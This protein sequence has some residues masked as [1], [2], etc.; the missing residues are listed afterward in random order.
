MS[1]KKMYLLIL[2]LAIIRVLY[3]FFGQIGVG[4]LVRFLGNNFIMPIVQ[5]SQIIHW[6][7]TLAIIIGLIISSVKEREKMA[8]ISLCLVFIQVLLRFGVIFLIRYF[9]NTEN[10]FIVSSFTTGQIIMYINFFML[11]ASL[12]INIMILIMITILYSRQAR[13]EIEDNRDIK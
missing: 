6:G 13:L 11:G 9:I 5:F 8:I 12:L 7:L 4:F 1:K 3:G 10:A 2:I